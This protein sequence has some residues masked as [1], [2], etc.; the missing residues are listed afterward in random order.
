MIKAKLKYLWITIFIIILI[1]I[2]QFFYFRSRGPIETDWTTVKSTMLANEDIARIVVVNNRRAN[3]YIK[4]NSLK[5]YQNEITGVFLKPLEYG[6]FFTFNIGSVE[7]FERNFSNAQEGRLNIIIPEYRSESNKI[8]EVLWTGG[9]F[10]LIL[11][12]I[13]VY[14]TPAYVAKGKKDF[15]SILILNILTGWTLIGWI[16]SLFWAI[17]SEPKAIRKQ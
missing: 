1:V 6:P 5:N 3:I 11:F 15:R 14:F 8:S 2:L 12:L 16:G 10:V 7:L 4:K 17:N 13:I 9:P